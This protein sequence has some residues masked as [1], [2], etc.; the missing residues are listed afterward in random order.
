MG[1]RRAGTPTRSAA[2]L[3]VVAAIAAGCGGGGGGGSAALCDAAREYRRQQDQL[4]GTKTGRA[5]IAGKIV[6][7]SNRIKQALP[8]DLRK[9][10]EPFEERLRGG[11]VAVLRDPKYI[12]ASARIATYLRDTCGVDIIASRFDSEASDGRVA[13]ATPPGRLRSNTT[14]APG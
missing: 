3:L 1:S 12:E 5:E 6:G 13:A 11:D 10:M 2:C 8:A 9:A 14:N 7:A 4:K